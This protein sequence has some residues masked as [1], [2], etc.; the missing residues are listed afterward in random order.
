MKEVSFSSKIVA[1]VI[2]VLLAIGGAVS[3]AKNN[4]KAVDATQNDIVEQEVL[5]E[6]DVADEMYSPLFD[7]HEWQDYG[8]ESVAEWYEDMKKKNEEAVGIADKTI[9]KYSGYVTD[10]Q[11]KKLREYE[12]IM[13]TTL[14]CSDYA[15]AK[16]KFDEIVDKLI[17]AS[18]PKPEPKPSTGG[19]SGNNG[20]G[21][22]GSGGGGYTGGGFNI[23]YNFKQMGVIYDSQ[24][25]YTYYSSRVLYHYMTPQWTLGSDGIYRDSAGRVVVA[26]DSYP[27]GTVLQTE[28]F[29]TCIVLDCGVGRND[30]LDVYVGW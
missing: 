13:S 4:D 7:K 3:Y 19:G 1:L 28:L 14:D 17:E 22:G 21:S 24:W 18:T 8:Y 12:E 25:R 16:K 5:N 6:E 27:H 15:D 9:S 29:G 11:K 26:C 30:T 2:V 23:P 10:E 20:G